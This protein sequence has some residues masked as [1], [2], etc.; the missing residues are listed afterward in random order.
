MLTKRIFVTV[1]ILCFLNSCGISTGVKTLGNSSSAA[2]TTPINNSDPFAISLVYRDSSADSTLSPVKV[3][4]VVGTTGNTA[5]SFA[6]TCGSDG[7]GCTCDLYQSTST[8]TPTTAVSVSYSLANNTIS[9]TTNSSTP[10][11]FAYVRLRTTS[12]TVVS[13]YLNVTNTLT[14]QQALNSTTLLA[15]SVRKIYNYKCTETFIEGEGVTISGTSFSDVCTQGQHLGFLSASYNYYLYAAE[16]GTDYN[17]GSQANTIP[18]STFC[19]KTVTQYSC[20]Q[21]GSSPAFGL[22]PTASGEFTYP[23]TVKPSPSLAAI[24][25]GYAALPDA[26][27]NCP[28]GLVKVLNFVASPPSVLAGSLGSNPQSNFININGSLND[29]EWLPATAFISNFT[30][31]RSPNSTPCATSVDSTNVYSCANAAASGGTQTLTPS[32]AYATQT[33]AVCAIPYNLL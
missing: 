28:V 23:I 1:A 9:C 8:T 27:G 3:F 19:E 20:G 4:Q 15:A 24:V 33:P 14:L 5:A 13:G 2:L 32:T 22:Y 30:V 21:M 18:Y 12:S 26:S 17:T 31:T 29:S 11:Q 10:S 6:S 25:E 16:S 7:S